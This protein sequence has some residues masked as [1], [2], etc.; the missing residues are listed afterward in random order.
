MTSPRSKGS[1]GFTLVELLVVIAIIAILIALLIPAVQKVR[2]A[3]AKSTCQNNLKQIGLAA[4]NYHDAFKSLPPAVQII[5]PTTSS[6][7]DNLSSYRNPGFG[8]NWAVLLLPYLEQTALYQEAAPDITNF[9]PSN[10]ANRNWRNVKSATIETFLCPT[11]SGNSTPCSLNLGNWARGNYA[12]NAGPDWISD[13]VGGHA[14]AGN[15]GVMCINWG[16]PLPQLSAEDG[17]AYTI[18]FNEIRIGLTGNDRRGTWA[19]GVGGSSI[20]GAMARGDST[21]PND[22]LEYSDDIEDCNQVRSDLGTGNN[23]LGVLMMGCS[24]DNLPQNWPNWQAQARSRHT[25]GVN[26]CFADGG[27]RFILNTVNESVWLNLNARDDGNVIHPSD[28]E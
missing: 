1:A 2:E 21:N 5:K 14:E 18:M 24:N 23:G 8:P 26:V 27:V 15:G 11:D 10:G 7:N 3:A 4:H 19:M 22:T 9:F 6:Q 28:V 13:T 12:A 17:T 25:G 16:V 20:T